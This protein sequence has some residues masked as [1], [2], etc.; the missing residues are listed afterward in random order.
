MYETVIGLEV[1]AELNTK[2]KIFCSCPIRYNEKPNLCVCPVCMGL[3]GALPVLN[4][5]VLEYAIKLGLATGCKI[6]TLSQ[7]SRKN[8]FYPDLPKGYQI[9]QDRLPVCYDGYVQVEGKKIRINRIHIEEDAGKLVHCEGETRIDYNRAGVPLVEIVTEPDIRSAEE[10]R[11]FMERIKGILLSLDISECKMERGHLRCDV[12]VSVRKIGDTALGERCEMKNINSFSA[13]V[14]SIEYEIKRQTEILKGGG[15]IKRETRRWDDEAR[16]SVLLRE[17]ESES[18]YR[19]FPE[20]D[21]PMMVIKKELIAKLS[22]EMPE[23]IHEKAERYERD[24]ALSDYDAN[25]VASCK[26]YAELFEEAVNYGADAKTIT[27]MIL[28]DISR[29]VNERGIAPDDLTLDGKRLAELDGMIKRN[30][31]SHTV[32]GRVIELLADCGKS[33]FDI[34]KENNFTQLNDAQI[35]EKL[36]KEVLGENEK[37][38]ADYKRGKTNAL[39]YLTGQCMKKSGGKANPV[40]VNKI[41]KECLEAGE[42]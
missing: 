14:R 24:Y 5:K 23:L 30:E 16:K 12:N 25:A 1:H 3:P 29:I 17:K 11:A 15:V 18:D 26:K 6:N 27:N 40:T 36:V 19:Y 9:S 20:P 38:I 33:A 41:L 34:V 31:V 32:A 2:T 7:H 39:G 37:S 13:A 8:Y 35:L 28:G 42:W 21:L 10:A 22:S 4:E